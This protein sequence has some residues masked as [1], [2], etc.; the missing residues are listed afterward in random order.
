MKLFAPTTICWA[1]LVLLGTGQAAEKPTPYRPPRL[2]DGH[3]DMEGV[4]KNSNLTPLER[5]QEFAQ[6]TITAADAKRLEAQY[7]L[8]FGGGGNKPNDPGIALEARSFEPIRGE[9]RSAQIIDPQDGKIPWKDGYK[10][11]IVEWRRAVLNAFDNPEQRPTPERCLSSNGAPPMQPTADANMFQLVQTPANTVILSE[12]I[13]DAR[14]VRMNGA[15]SPAMVTSWLGDSIGWWEGNTLVIET[16]HFSPTSAVRSSARHF[17]LVSPQTTVIEKFTR[18]SDNELNYV[19]NVTDPIYYTRDWTG[20]TNLRR[21]TKRIFEFACHEGN[22]SVRDMLEA[23]RV[24][25]AK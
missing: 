6:L 8:D 23:A 20:E 16:K 7:H 10:D 24:N 9:L 19:F 21:S 25:E 15:H 17:F 2:P 5:P 22:Y 14:M 3:V 13:H 12:F 11:R 4:W 18:V 1:L